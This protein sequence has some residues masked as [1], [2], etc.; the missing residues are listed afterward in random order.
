MR[1]YWA[2][3]MNCELRNVIVQVHVEVRIFNIRLLLFR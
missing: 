1:K 3:L 2:W